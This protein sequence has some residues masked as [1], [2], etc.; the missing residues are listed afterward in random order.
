MA[1]E[2]M[3]TGIG[4]VPRQNPMMP[5]IVD[6]P[7]THG[8]RREP[9]NIAEAVQAIVGGVKSISGGAAMLNRQQ[10]SFNE[11]D[12]AR[13]AALINRQNE[14][15]AINDALHSH[16]VSAQ[17]NGP[18]MEY[19]NNFDAAKGPIAY[20]PGVKPTD[21]VRQAIGNDLSGLDPEVQQWAV[22]HLAQR[23]ATTWDQKAQQS[24]K[25]D[26]INEG[27]S[28]PQRLLDAQSDPTVL[29]DFPSYY[30]RASKVL[31]PAAAL[32]PLRSALM[33]GA[34]RGAKPQVEALQGLANQYGL[35]DDYDRAVAEAQGVRD[36]EQ[37]RAAT[38]EAAEEKAYHAST[39]SQLNNQ[40]LQIDQVDLTPLERHT[41]AEELRQAILDDTRL[42]G[43]IKMQR[44][45]SLDTWETR[46]GWADMG[47]MNLLNKR[48]DDVVQ[49]HNTLGD[50]A[51]KSD[52][53]EAWNRGDM[54][55]GKQANGRYQEMLDRLDKG[56]RNPAWDMTAGVRNALRKDVDRNPSKYPNGD[57][58]IYLFE[59]DLRQFVVK[60]NPSP[61]QAFNYAKERMVDFHKLT[62]VQTG[63]QMNDLWVQM[64][65]ALDM[66]D[67]STGTTR[68]WRNSMAPRVKT[69]ADYEKVPDGAAYV[70]PVGSLLIKTPVA[71]VYTKEEFDRLPSGAAYIGPSGIP[72]RKP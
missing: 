9:Y 30:D 58:Q 61:E 40:M 65:T 50:P 27:M 23:T 12:Q 8:E 11:E 18:A 19:I 37:A 44:S 45:N 59:S 53:D 16:E 36:R 39:L 48:I 47:Q 6:I 22:N 25:V 51:L 63:T 26:T 71:H 41:K 20:Q 57:E 56:Q 5:D 70:N 28:L 34:I 69:R 38:L 42:P 67:T 60:N 7:V 62:P 35:K 43:D 21:A 64:S 54:G 15:T 10:K 13:Q 1:N 29:K 32:E 3:N 24:I 46:A 4:A 31:S 52:I 2:P 17:R 33:S 68:F 49:S 72:K 66:P 55:R 14:Q